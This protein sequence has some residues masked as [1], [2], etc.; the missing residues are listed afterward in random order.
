ML[1][2]WRGSIAFADDMAIFRGPVA[3]N[4]AHS[5]WVSQLTIALDGEVR[6]CTSEGEGSAEAVYFASKTEHRL[7][8]G[9]I[10][11]VY[12]DPMLRS[13]LDAFDARA[14]EGWLALSRDE[15]PAPLAEITAETDLAA[16]IASG[17]LRVQ[18]SSRSSDGRLDKV[19]RAIR[20][21]IVDGRGVDRNSLAKLTSLSPSRFSHWFVEQTG[22]PLRS[23]KKWLKLRLALDALLDGKR[24]AEAAMLSG[25]SDQAHM[26]RVISESFGLTYMDVMRAWQYAQTVV[27]DQGG[28]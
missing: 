2:Q 21:S 20:E 22:V 11:S 18:P 26:S 28:V 19:M 14:P 9:L 12:F 7:L 15:L 8:S 10:C 25:F 6:F 23:Y 5:H 27:T 17:V 13:P 24:P 16:L 4:D 1:K 3:G